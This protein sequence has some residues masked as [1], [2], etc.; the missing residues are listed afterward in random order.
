MSNKQLAVLIVAIF[1]AALLVV[2][3]MKGWF[4]FRSPEERRY[5]EKMDALNESLENTQDTADRLNA[6]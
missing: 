2:G 3:F 6:M 4:D 1:A 5:D